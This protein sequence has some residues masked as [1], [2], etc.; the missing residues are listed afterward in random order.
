MCR[1]K[2]SAACGNICDR[3]VR[4][5]L[6][7][8]GTIWLE[9]R[10]DRSAHHCTREDHGTTRSE[11]TRR[12]CVH[13]LVTR[14]LARRQAEDGTV[15]WGEGG[16]SGIINEMLAPLLIGKDAMDRARLWEEMFHSLYNGN[17][18]VGLA[19]SAISALDIALCVLCWLA[20]Q[21][22]ASIGISVNL[23]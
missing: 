15:G 2:P 7:A 4:C 10:L 19:G 18:A 8:C 6:P 1:D 16:S 11:L 22:L 14:L 5:C 9:P 21:F 12:C 17:N 13:H 3:Y 23:P 20:L